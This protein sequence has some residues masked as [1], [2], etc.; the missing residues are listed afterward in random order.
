MLR[1]EAVPMVTI[2]G[3]L[4]HKRRIENKSTPVQRPDVPNSDRRFITPRREQERNFVCGEFDWYIPVNLLTI[5][6]SLRPHS[7]F[8]IIISTPN[9]QV[10]SG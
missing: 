3:H 2:R 6:E 5:V 10:K 7:I 1:K 4:L 9:Q 8:L